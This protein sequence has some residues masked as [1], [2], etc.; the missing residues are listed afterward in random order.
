MI[1]ILYHRIAKFPWI[2]NSAQFLT[3]LLAGLGLI[4][5]SSPSM[6]DFRP[7]SGRLVWSDEFNEEGRP[8]SDQWSYRTGGHG[9]GNKELQHYTRRPENAR[10]KNG[11]LIIQARKESNAFTSARLR[12][13][14]SWKYGR[15]EVRAKLPSGRGTWAAIWML[16][17]D[18]TYGEKLW[19][20][21]GEID[22][23]EH[24]GHRPDLIHGGIHTAAYNHED[25]T[26]K[27]ESL[28]LGGARKS[29]NVYALEWTPAEIRILANDRVYFTYERPPSAPVAEWPFDQ[30]FYL[31]LNVAVGGRWGGVQ[32]VAP[33][34]WPQQM[35]VDYVRIY[36][37]DR[38]P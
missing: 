25:D 33:D 23:M 14:E 12:S 24:V 29:F 38:I 28:R 11:H 35:V 21:N 30:E 27:G 10:V 4:S 9:W 22:I 19:P 2:K 1:G 5:C 16:P 31:I 37:P 13:V 6:T 20:R 15:V 3:V 36:A 17:E 32:G 34:I 7:E 18:I 26:K 8:D